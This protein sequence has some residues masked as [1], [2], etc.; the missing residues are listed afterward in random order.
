MRSDQKNNL[1]PHNYMIQGIDCTRNNDTNNL[2]IVQELWQK[3]LEWVEA[4][5]LSIHTNWTRLKRE[6]Q[7]LNAFR[8]PRY[9]LHSNA[10]DNRATWIL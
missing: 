4:V 1:T 10:K 7:L 8:I 2:A 5:P 6:P 3:K 9:T